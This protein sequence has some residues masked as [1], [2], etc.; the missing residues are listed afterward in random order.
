[1]EQKNLPVRQAVLGLLMTTLI[2]IS[3]TAVAIDNYATSER[4]SVIVN[5]YGECW[6]S[7]GGQSGNCSA[8]DSDGDGVNDHKDKCPN[9]PKGA[10]VDK[11]GCALDS[12]GDGVTDNKDRCP[13]TPRGVDVYVDGCPL[14]TDMDGVP[15]YLDKCPDTERGKSVN[16]EGCHLDSDGDGVTDEMDRCPDTPK[17]AEVDSNGCME[18]LVLN[19]VEFETAS[20]RLTE[21]AMGELA[22]V[23]EAL[24]IRTNIKQLT[25]VGH[26]DS[27]GSA[28]YNQKLS[29][30]RAQAVADYLSANGVKTAITASGKGESDP[31]ADNASEEGR[32]RN[33]RVELSVDD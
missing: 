31:V 6:Q 4:G 5:S 32:A 29:E 15:D 18:K 7:I 11:D 25:V 30:S 14:D 17:G 27:Q 3:S 16:A 9:T 24:R 20:A 10:P 19:N 33:R 2:V 1:M 8:N 22:V 21:A 28:A 23:A 26:T 12:D 13:E